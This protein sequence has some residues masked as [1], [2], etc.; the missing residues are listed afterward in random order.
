MA[1]QVHEDLPTRIIRVTDIKLS[2]GSGQIITK[3]FILCRDRPA[4]YPL[5]TPRL[6]INLPR[7]LWLVLRACAEFLHVLCKVGNGISARLPSG[8]LKIDK[9][10]RKS[11]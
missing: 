5:N 1:D 8:A 11:V 2:E 9:R 10:D 6:I 3:H 7:V 4:P